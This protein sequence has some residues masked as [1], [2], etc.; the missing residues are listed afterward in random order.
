MTCTSTL[1]KLGQ[2]S[3]ENDSIIAC[4]YPRLQGHLWWH[5]LQQSLVDHRLEITGSSS[6]CIRLCTHLNGHPQQYVLQQIPTQTTKKWPSG[7]YWFQA[8][9]VSCLDFV[10]NNKVN[11]VAPHRPLST[12]HR[13]P[14]P[15]SSSTLAFPICTQTHLMPSLETRFWMPRMSKTSL[16]TSV[17]KC[18]SNLVGFILRLHSLM[19]CPNETTNTH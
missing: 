4:S 3:L 9:L 10:I 6:V 8:L 19:S 12:V 7:I 17:T 14:F 11:T 16:W 15:A 2:L 13:D 18:W 1:T 5:I